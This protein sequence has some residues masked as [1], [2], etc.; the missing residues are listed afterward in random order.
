MRRRE[1]PNDLE[2]LVVSFRIAEPDA[3]ERASA[4]PQVHLVIVEAGQEKATVEIDDASRSADIRVDVGP[5]AR[6]DDSVIA[7]R[8][9]AL[10]RTVSENEVRGRRWART[11]GDEQDPRAPKKSSYV[12]C[13][14]RATGRGESK[15]IMRTLA[16]STS[17][18]F[19][20]NGEPLPLGE[21]SLIGARLLRELDPRAR[22]PAPGEPPYL[23]CGNGTCRDCNVWIDGL[24]DLPSCRLPLASGLSLACTGEGALPSR[25]VLPLGNPLRCDVLVVGAGE[26]GLAAAAASRRTA[27]TVL[28]V[29]ARRLDDEEVHSLCT[30]VTEAGSLVV[31]HQGQK[32]AVHAG[33][34]VLATG[35][36]D[37]FPTFPGSTRPGIMPMDLLERYVT[38]GY[39]AGGSFLLIGSRA[40]VGSLRVNLLRL[41]AERV[42]LAASTSGAEAFD[43]VAVEGRRQPSLELAKG[44]GCRTHYD[45][46]LRFEQLD[47]TDDGR[48]SL[49]N[50]FVAGSYVRTD[51]E[52]VGRAAARAR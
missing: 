2:N 24:P 21:D 52:S 30:A 7:D 17:G 40:R 44:L 51:G 39:L 9:L 38:H 6:R 27:R 33:S 13:G 28:H 45:R 46:V 32:R 34:V 25:V 37:V 12:H 31:L 29:D 5:I 50:V 16:S 19:F 4:S 36:R 23:F 11:T 48:T 3:I 20:L 15:S 49:A 26:A 8:D 22:I 14:R 1:D 47:V 18:T 42:E 10:R 41:G 35:W 43:V